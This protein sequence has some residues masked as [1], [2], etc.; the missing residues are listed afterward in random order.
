MGDVL[1]RI[2]SL[3]ADKLRGREPWAKLASNGGTLA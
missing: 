3:H 1:I 2:I